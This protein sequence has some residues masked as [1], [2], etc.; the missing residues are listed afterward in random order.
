L[1]HIIQQVIF[2]RSNVVYGWSAA[3]LLS[4]AA[5][6]CGDDDSPPAPDASRPDAAGAPD[7][8]PPDAGPPPDYPK[9][10]VELSTGI[11]MQYVEVGGAASGETVIMLH[12]FTDSSRSFF[13]TIQA[14]TA[15]NSA[16]RIYALDLRGHG[17]SSMPEGASCP[18][19]PATC[20][21]LS[22]FAD[23]VFAFMAAKEITTAHLVGH[24]LGS[25]V[26][27]EIATAAPGSVESLVLISSSANTM[28]NPVLEDVILAGA[29]EGM[30]RTALEEDTGFEWPQDAYAL[31]PLDAD[32]SA[33]TWLAM[34]W[35]LDPTANPDFIEAIVPETARVRL[36]TWLGVVDMLLANDNSA[37]LRNLSVSSLILWGTQDVLFLDADQMALRTALDAA[38]A[39]CRSGY[40]WK[41]YGK[42]ALPASGRQESDLG[43]NPHWGAPSQVAADIDAFIATG[44]PTLDLYFANPA[45]L[46]DIETE[47]GEADLIEKPA[48][49]G[50]GA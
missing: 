48:A 47:A 27:Q 13:P 50:C 30:W 26:A 19:A 5:A 1:R 31:T 38:A 4:L 17:D 16:L 45:A 36:G 34:N 41:P 39:A 21:E 44:R 40:I 9:Q 23:D 18:A 32:A 14:L 46:T 15:R 24:S 43:R 11:D 25:L 12:G 28:A 10:T 33:E 22:D 8:G 2:M 37:R 49:T 6:G 35:V 42:A 3:A 7:A 20:F 29:I